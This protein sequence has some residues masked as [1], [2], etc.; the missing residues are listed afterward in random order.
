MTSEGR[1]NVA[2]D[3]AVWESLHVTSGDDTP[4]TPETPTPVSDWAGKLT[5]IGA[6]LTYAALV[7]YLVRTTRNSPE[8]KVPDISDAVAGTTAALAAV[9]GIAF[10]SVLGVPP[11]APPDTPGLTATKP[12]R[13][14]RWL[15]SQFNLRN[16]LA[17]GVAVYLLAGAALGA[18]YLKYNK[19]APGVVKTIAIAF[20]GYVIAYI[21]KA[22]KDYRG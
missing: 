1:P 18:T 9:F 3:T 8:G 19:E 4:K 22:Y 5:L 11:A 17:L 14:F 10:A 15:G 16:L 6:E 7:V 13:F 20:G 2:N 12:V 21:G